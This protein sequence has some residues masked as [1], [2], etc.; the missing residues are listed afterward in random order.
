MTPARRFT[1]R[2]RIACLTFTCALAA[3]SSTPPGPGRTVPLDPDEEPQTEP[4]CDAAATVASDSRALLVTDP[5]ALARFPL[6]SVLAQILAR[7]MDASTTP[8]ELLQRLFD[9]D[10]PDGAA[11]FADGVHCDSAL[12]LAHA[13]GPAAFCPR[14]EGVLSA[15][16]GLLTPGHPDHFFPVAV[17]NR[18]DLTPVVG[19]TCGE[20]RIIYAKESGLT[21]PDD[22]VFLIFESTLPN[23]DFGE[24]AGCRPVA[25]LWKSL[26]NEP[27]AAAVGDR[28]HTFFFDGLPGFAPAIDPLRLGLGSLPGA[29]YYGGTGGQIRVSQ[30]M[31]EHWVM[32]Q[33]VMAASADGHLRFEPTTVGNNPL[34][35]LFGPIAAN[36]YIYTDQAN[37]ADDL[38]A[39]SIETLAAPRVEQI[40]MTVPAEHL[41]GESALGGDALNDYVGL[42]AGNPYLTDAITARIAELGLGADCPADDPLTVDS[43][44][45]RATVDSCA[46]CHAPDQLLGPERKLGCGLTWP[47]SL[48]EVHIDEHGNVSPALKEVFLPHRA[49]ILTRYLQACGNEYE[50]AASLNVATA[51]GATTKSMNRRR[52]IG[53]SVTH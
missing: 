22:R 28:L 43:I 17:V 14:V 44:L 48:G 36:D 10:N 19:A 6:E 50:M 2:S 52:T 45:R 13:N 3:C 53:G 47:A 23:P 9:T 33:L 29:G 24:L 49:D 1:S 26:E 42:G 41:S 39:T 27:S 12:N 34:P 4:A 5:A 8:L 46:G 40:R 7:G 38:A 20:Y 21:D 11:V 18:F 51:G 32:R 15:S 30:H 31:D 37:F 25:E 16:P 35:R